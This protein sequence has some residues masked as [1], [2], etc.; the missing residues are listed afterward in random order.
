MTCRMTGPKE[1]RNGPCG[2]VRP[3]GKCVVIPEMDSVWMLAWERSERMRTFGERIQVLRPPVD[4]QVQGSS[5][6]L[7]RL[8]ERDRPTPTGRIA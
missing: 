8:S 1:M 3:A 7:N 2:G 6:W 5:A 4:R